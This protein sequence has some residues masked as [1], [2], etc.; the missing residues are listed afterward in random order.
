MKR[1]Q[2]TQLVGVT[3][4]VFFLTGTIYRIL[5]KHGSLIITRIFAVLVAAIVVQDVV[6]GVKTM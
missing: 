6:D 1:G 5:G 2:L 4:V 3:C